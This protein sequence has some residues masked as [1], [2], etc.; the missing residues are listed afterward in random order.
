VGKKERRREGRKEGRK[1]RKKK[2]KKSLFTGPAFKAYYC[3]FAMLFPDFSS[4][5]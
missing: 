1:E 4:A 5:N 3:Y 2:R